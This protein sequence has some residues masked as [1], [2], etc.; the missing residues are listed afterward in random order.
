MKKFNNA[1]IEK[2]I[3]GTLLSG[4]E[5]IDLLITELRSELFYFSK[6]KIIYESIVAV[7]R[8]GFRVDILTISNEIDKINKL[9][10]VG[11][12]SYLAESLVAGSTLSQ[13][14]HYI[15]ILKEDYKTRAIAKFLQDNLYKIKENDFES[16]EQIMT[17]ISENII[18]L[19]N[20][21]VKEETNLK[22][23]IEEFS[24]LQEQ[25]AINK[26][27]GKET[28][29]IPTGYWSL[30]RLIDGFRQEHF[31]T[32]AAG[33]SIGKTT[34][35]IN[36]AYNIVS[37]GKRVVIFSLEMSKNDIISKFLAIRMGVSPSII[38][39]CYTDDV[40]YEKQ[41][42][43]KEW[44]SNKN[45]TIYS[46]LDDIDDIAMMMIIEQ[47][48]QPV[49]LFILDYIQNISS[50]KDKDQYSLLTNGV[51]LLQKTNRTL[52][53]TL[54]NISQISIDT[55]KSGSTLNVEGKETG[56]IKNASNVFIYIKRDLE[57]EEDVNRIIQNGEDMPML[58]V[59]NKN[60]H[61]AIG[62]FKLKMKLDSG[63]MYQP[64]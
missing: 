52:K 64:I 12:T 63:E 13:A 29:G 25:Y 16:P 62:A 61:G 21:S 53:T 44:L 45:I 56:A 31:I 19:S 55:K 54:L 40:L 2:A 50:K 18:N 33:T 15:R 23:N 43:A 22:R 24:N 3:I 39:K 48:K 32:L 26:L 20:E 38:T 6:N 11:G 42:V 1:E 34:M 10:Q 17:D 30:D 57:N 51:K 8:N 36:L 60:R 7:Y 5:K 27:S 41:K 46:D 37:I 28:I 47:S 14:L 4:I 9:E 49:N 35:A 58:C 59:V